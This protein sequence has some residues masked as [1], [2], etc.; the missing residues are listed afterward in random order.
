MHAQQV[1][2]GLT[3]HAATI[4]QSLDRVGAT[5]QQRADALE[6]HSA[7]VHEVVELERSLQRTLRTLEET[8]ELRSTLLGV[9]GSLQGLQ[10][11]LERLSQP[12]RIML[13]E[14]DGGR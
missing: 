10:P 6:R 1:A 8:G 14:A 9:Q 12:R 7:A 5:L 3:Q 13:V 2:T 11:A 4:A